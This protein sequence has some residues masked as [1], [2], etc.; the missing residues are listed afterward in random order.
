MQIFFNS[1]NTNYKSLKTKN[2]AK[3]IQSVNSYNKT[4]ELFDKN[5]NNVFIKKSVSFEG[6]RLSIQQYDNL[7]KKNVF[8]KASKYFRRGTYYG[9]KH[10]NEDYKD[11]I[12]TL[13]QV[14]KRKK[15]VKI[16]VAGVANAEEPSSILATISELTNHKPIE[17]TVDL[18]LVDIN[19]CPSINKKVTKPDFCKS[20]FEPYKENDSCFYK[21]KDSIGNY[22]EE[23]YKDCDPK[24]P[25]SRSKWGV[26]IKDFVKTAPDEQY[27]LI[28][29]NNVDIYI[30]NL[31][32]KFKIINNMFRILKK[33]GFLITDQSKD[34]SYLMVACDLKPDSFKEIKPGIFKKLK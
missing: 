17:K 23:V 28:S 12:Y 9:E 26:E 31:K 20:S 19:P 16:L 2:C 10:I 18:N 32:D 34:Y 4:T 14:L 24:N 15:P 33:G 6:K 30:K 1:Y 5:Y 13:K 8:L 27:D 22:L 29:Y 21:I 3:S 11:V 7:C 25:K